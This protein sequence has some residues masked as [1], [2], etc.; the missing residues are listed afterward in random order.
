MA[1]NYITIE[2]VSKSYGEKE[3]FSSVG[4]GINKGQ[5]IA[6]VAENGSGKSTLMKI[7]ANRETPDNGSVSFRKSIAVSYLEQHPLQTE[8][9]S[10]I[11]VLFN[12]PTPLMKTVKRYEQALLNST[13][14]S[15]ENTEK[16]LS[17]AMLEMDCQNAW[18]YESQIKEILGKLNITDLTKNVS[19]LSGGEKKKVA[20][21]AVLISKSE[22]LLLDEPTNHL[23]IEMIE[24]LEE[25]LSTANQT[26]L[27][28]SHDRYFID[29]VSTEIYEL[30]KGQ[31]CKYE[32]KFDYYL[33]KKAQRQQ[34][35]SASLAKAK[36][37]YKKELEWIRRMP[38]AR[39][40]KSR[41]RIEAFNE[42]KETVSNVNVTKYAELTVKAQRIGGK[43]L[44]INNINKSFGE[45]KIIDDFSHIYK[46]GDKIGIIGKNGSGKTTLLDIITEKI[47]PDSGKVTLGQ[48]IKIGY[49]TQNPLEEKPDTK[50]IDIVK[51]ISENILLAD[52]TSMGASQYLTHFGIPPYKQ[53]THY[54]NLSGGEKR[55]LNLLCILMA[56]PNFLILDEP[57][58][59]L[60]IHT[61]MKLETFLEQYQGC[62]MIVSHDRH[63][64]DR[65]VSQLFV[66]NKEGKIKEFPG[67]YTDYLIK[68]KENQ[69]QQRLIEDKKEKPT[70]IK[71][72]ES[73]NKVKLTYKEQKEKEEIEDL[74]PKM[75]VRKKDIEKLL[76][77]GELINESLIEITQ[78]YQTLLEEIEQKEFR[79]L[80]LCSK[81]QDEKEE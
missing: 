53:H 33:E 2:N 64:L 52:G 50:V 41:A 80:E 67:N 46:K 76:S 45:R 56:N 13:K 66:F 72:K 49:Y 47:K 51:K 8:N 4:F 44:E 77:S 69:K 42:L 57:T 18:N 78:E 29:K 17:D 32:G 7:I 9:A 25:Y 63:F 79:W 35:E 24:W 6:L 43:I 30:E 14:F 37:L 58:N 54:G 75:E 40:T 55:L 28:V 27:F 48:T 65:I 12:S 16:E 1:E 68:E 73:R 10:I 22:V 3:L 81:E 26:I 74:L 21:C 59:D 19:T 20:L 11:D 31:I 38:Q 71:K 23:D 60:D 39:G 34:Q 62:L 15:D 36:N 70:L 61:Q 5:K